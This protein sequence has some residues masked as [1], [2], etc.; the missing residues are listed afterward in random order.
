MSNDSGNYRSLEVIP[1]LINL[2]PSVGIS[3]ASTPKTENPQAMQTEI[4]RGLFFLS[5]G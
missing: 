1:L 5:V 3:F 4:A 2:E